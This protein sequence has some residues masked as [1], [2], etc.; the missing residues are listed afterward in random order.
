MCSPGQVTLSE[1][2]LCITSNDHQIYFSSI[3]G[4]HSNMTLTFYKIWTKEKIRLSYEEA[5]YLSRTFGRWDTRREKVPNGYKYHPL[6]TYPDIDGIALEQHWIDYNDQLNGFQV[7][8]CIRFIFPPSLALV[9]RQFLDRHL[10]DESFE[11]ED[12][13]GGIY[14]ILKVKNVHSK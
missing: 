10:K 2:N 3:P 14:K 8:N 12:Q 1:D 9:I 5:C 13:Y 7:H 4:L 11:G 6:L